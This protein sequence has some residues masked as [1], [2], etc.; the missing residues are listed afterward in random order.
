MIHDTTPEELLDECIDRIVRGEEWQS[1]VHA[2]PM[3]AQEIRGLATL[4]EELAGADGIT[5]SLLRRRSE[6]WRRIQLRL[7]QSAHPL[8]AVGRAIREW[9]R[10]A[11]AVAGMLATSAMSS[12]GLLTALAAGVRTLP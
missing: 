4:A 6:T 12:M 1:L 7:S 10:E 2:H 9:Q 8:A 11:P 5:D 3:L